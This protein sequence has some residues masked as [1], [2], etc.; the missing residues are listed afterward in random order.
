MKRAGLVLLL[1]ALTAGGV[2]AGGTGEKKGSA[3]GVGVSAPT[4]SLPIVKEKLTLK[5]LTN[6]WTGIVVGN[7]MPVYKELEKRT[8]VHLD[9]TLL[10]IQNTL[11]KFNLIMASGDLP[12]IVGWGNADAFNKFGMQGALVPLQDLIKKFGP[13]IQKAI[14]N[15]LPNDSLPYKLNAWAEL[16]AADGNLYTVPT[17]SSSSAIGPVFGIRTDWLDKLGLKV[18]DTTDDLYNALKAVTS[19]FGWNSRE[20]FLSESERRMINILTEI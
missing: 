8:N 14:E 4:G 16:R 2:M 5:M 10:P 3:S 18:P 12:D 9:I 11:D 13:D 17:I 7:D 6:D 20:A 19:H 15:P 1:L